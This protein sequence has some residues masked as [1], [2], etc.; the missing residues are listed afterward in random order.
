MER[1][2]PP[3]KLKKKLRNHWRFAKGPI[4]VEIYEDVFF[5][6][7]VR[8]RSMDCIFGYPPNDVLISWYETHYP[9]DK[10]AIHYC[11]QNRYNL[12]KIAYDN[13]I[14]HIRNYGKIQINENLV[15]GKVEKS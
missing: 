1:L 11:N 9:D 12:N 4:Y 10:L 7:R 14:L 3:R 5:K 15:F 2:N 6:D 13:R 8:I